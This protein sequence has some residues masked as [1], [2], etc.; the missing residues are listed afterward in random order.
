MFLL[1]ATSKTRRVL[2]VAAL[3]GRFSEEPTQYSPASH[4]DGAEPS[5]H[6]RATTPLETL[7]YTAETDQ[8]N[9]HPTM[10]RSEGDYNILFNN[11]RIDE[12]TL[13]IIKKKT[14]NLFCACYNYNFLNHN[15]LSDLA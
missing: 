4:H 12:V 11:T 2:C 7:S 3:D 14:E 15:S 10:M 1:Y 13:L 9:Y 5:P 8:E 6:S